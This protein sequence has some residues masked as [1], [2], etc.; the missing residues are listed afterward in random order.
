MRASIRHIVAATRSDTSSI[1]EAE[2]PLRNREVES[3]FLT[4]RAVLAQ[5]NVKPPL[6]RIVARLITW[7]GVSRDVVAWRCCCA[8]YCA[9]LLNH[10]PWC[11]CGCGCSCGRGYRRSFW[12]RRG[13]GFSRENACRRHFR[14]HYYSRSFDE[15]GSDRRTLRRRHDAYGRTRTRVHDPGRAL[16]PDRA[17]RISALCMQDRSLLGLRLQLRHK[18][19]ATRRQRR[20]NRLHQSARSNRRL[21][22]RPI[23]QREDHRSAYRSADRG[24]DDKNARCAQEVRSWS[25]IS[26]FGIEVAGV[27]RMADCRLSIPSFGDPCPSRFLR[28]RLKIR[29]RMLFGC[30]MVCQ[31]GQRGS[32]ALYFIGA[33]AIVAPL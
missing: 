29:P 1:A 20:L 19:R 18:R 27:T 33:V 9:R 14:R 28:G 10:C 8:R 26:P 21:G 25:N 5:E 16:R 23:H 32:F 6:H 7:R 17:G 22:R 24:S 13:V 12:H 31:A 2:L 11:G 30:L 3:V 4:V 15:R